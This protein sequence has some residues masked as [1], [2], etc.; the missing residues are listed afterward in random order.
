MEKTQKTTCLRCTGKMS[1]I[2]I[3]KIQLGQTGLLLGMWN[4]I[5][6]GSMEVE[7][8]VC[9]KCK[10]VELY[11]NNLDSSCDDIPKK[12]CP[13]CGKVHDFDYPKCPFCKYQY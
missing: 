8:Y 10:K 11:A 3:E 13:Q 5:L 6:A 2:G 9:S 7:I 12:T 1:S 4:N